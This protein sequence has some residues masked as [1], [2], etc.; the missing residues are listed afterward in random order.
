MRLFKDA[1]NSHDQPLNRIET[2]NGP[3]MLNSL[4]S[5]PAG[6]VGIQEFLPK[7]PL[8]WTFQHSEV[9]VVLE[10]EAQITFSMPPLH[11]QKEKIIAKAGDVLFI[12]AGE[13]VLFEVISDQPFRHLCVIMPYKSTVEKT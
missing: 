4:F 12:Y 7:E 10:G 5:E 8:D 2:I 1:L 13:R 6:L 9:L 11:A 3:I